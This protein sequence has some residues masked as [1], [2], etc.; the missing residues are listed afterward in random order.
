MKSKIKI[1]FWFSYL[2]KTKLPTDQKYLLWKGRVKPEVAR[3]QRRWFRSCWG[4]FPTSSPGSSRFPEDPG[5]EVGSVPCLH[6]AVS[7]AN[8]T[9]QQSKAC[10]YHGRDVFK[11]MSWSF[12]HW[13]VCFCCNL[14]ALLYAITLCWVERLGSGSINCGL[15]TTEYKK[16]RPGIKCELHAVLVRLSLLISG[17]RS[18]ARFPQKT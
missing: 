1:V 2:W 8:V 18:L 12:F 4:V 13:Q 17:S 11:E 7:R 5:D 10:L 3:L 6:G 14:A 15:Q 16:H 9:Q